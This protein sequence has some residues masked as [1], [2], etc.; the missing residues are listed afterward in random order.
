MIIGHVNQFCDF[1]NIEADHGTRLVTH[2]LRNEHQCLHRY[3]N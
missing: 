2:I 3:A 1:L